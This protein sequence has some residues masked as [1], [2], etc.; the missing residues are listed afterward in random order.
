MNVKKIA[1][2][3]ILFFVI[4]LV[5]LHAQTLYV[6]QRTGLETTF[7]FDEV[8]KIVFPAGYLQVVK[9]DGVVSDYLFS[10]VR[11]LSFREYV[12]PITTAVVGANNADSYSLFPNPVK[13][14]FY[15]KSIDV[16]S[17][18]IINSVGEVVL[19]DSINQSSG[20]NVES[21]SSGV[22]LCRIDIDGEHFFKRFIK[23]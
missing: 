17:V 3:L 1:F 21:L 11:Y 5:P 10:D 23:E 14:V 18:E 19:T 12:T 15:I 7:S 20:I 6:K 22:Y 13:N 9:T 8:R 4:K 16:A 2:L